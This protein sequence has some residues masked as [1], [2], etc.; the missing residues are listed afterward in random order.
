ME[1]TEGYERISVVSA[2]PNLRRTEPQGLGV[3]DQSKLGR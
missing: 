1:L 3:Y 2:R